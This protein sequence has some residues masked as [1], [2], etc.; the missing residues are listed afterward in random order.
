MRNIKSCFSICK[1]GFRKW[2]SSYRMYV[3]LLLLILFTYHYVRPFYTASVQVDKSIPVVVFPF[4][5]NGTFTQAI[6]M[7]GMVFLFC[8][9]PFMDNIQLYTII[10]SGKQKWA[11]GQILYMILASA[12][13][14]LTI[15]LLTVLMLVPNIDFADKWGAIFSTLAQGASFG[16]IAISIPQKIVA[17]YSPM[18]AVVISFLLEWGAIVFMA[19]LLFAINLNCNR[20]IGIVSVSSLILFDAAVYNNWPYSYNKFSPVSMARLTTLDALGSNGRPT[21]LYAVLFYGIGILF[22]SAFCV[23]CVRKKA[24]KMEV[25]L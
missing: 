17:L 10:R 20:I 2:S 18:E 22:L 1:N 23:L 14:L 8:D 5:T 6:I 21:L 15:F 11:V 25:T 13:Y 9:A 7:F 16:N 4:L 3:L 19:L 24:V 12:V